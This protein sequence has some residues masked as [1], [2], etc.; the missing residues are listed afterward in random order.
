MKTTTAASGSVA[1][2]ACKLVIPRVSGAWKYKLTRKLS[3]AIAPAPIRIAP[4][5]PTRS[6]LRSRA[7]STSGA[8]TRR[9][10]STN[11]ITASTDR[12]RHS[13]VG[14]DSQPQDDP[15]VMANTNGTSAAATRPVPARSIFRGRSGSRDSGT[16]PI[17]T[18]MHATAIAA[19]IQNSP[20]QPVNSLS[21]PPST[22]PAA[23]PA[24]AAAP[25]RAT[26]R[27]RAAP[28]DATDSKL[29]PQAKIVAPAAP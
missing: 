24:A 23:A 21:T 5:A 4:V 29:N 26:A 28:E 19:S 25:Q 18:A 14:G 12:T 15:S 20:C 17:V 2:P 16:V 11:P 22:G 10:T 7:R 3:A 6:M 9:S 8:A 27:I 1:K 13:R